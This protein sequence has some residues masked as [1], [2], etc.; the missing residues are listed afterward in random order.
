MDHIVTQYRE[1]MKSKLNPVYII[2]GLF[3]FKVGVIDNIRFPQNNS[4]Q[5]TVASVDLTKRAIR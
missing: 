4:G 2:I 5:R 3:L 1:L